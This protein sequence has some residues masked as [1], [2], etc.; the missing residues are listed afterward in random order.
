MTAESLTE[1][2]SQP[3]PCRTHGLQLI[4][5]FEGSGF[6]EPHYLARRADGHVIHLSR[7]LYLVASHIDGQRGLEEIADRVSEDFG[8]FVSADNVAYLLERKLRPLGVAAIEGV[9]TLPEWHEPLLGIKFRFAI[10]PE[11]VVNALASLL[12]PLFLPPI[13]AVVLGSVAAVYVWVFAFHGFV[14]PFLDVL[15]RP[16]TLLAIFAIGLLYTVFH[17]LGH[18]TACRYGGAR[19]GVMGVGLYIVW[20]VFYTDVTDSYRVSRRGRIRTDLGGVYFHALCILATAGLYFLTGQEWLLVLLLFTHLEMIHQFLPV[21][22]LDGYWLV[23]DLTGVPDLFGRMGPIL[24]SL[25]PGRPPEPK[26]DQ[27]KPWARRCITAW[28]LVTVPV[29]VGGLIWFIFHLPLL[30]SA[31]WEAIQAQSEAIRMARASGDWPVVAVAV[32]ELLL[33][34]LPVLATIATS[35]WISW[36]LGRAIARRWGPQRRTPAAGTPGAQPM[37]SNRDERAGHARDLRLRVGRASKRG[38]HTP[39]GELRQDGTERERGVR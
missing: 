24:R 33:L 27:L 32:L 37:P 38:V 19:P 16:L 8:R 35:A 12:G 30:A 36:R 3:V 15:H 39:G 13:V 26:V 9:D 7:L 11:R 20:P 5:D 6:V 25:L 2:P 4:G 10:M 18:A 34:V 29:L 22:R 17:E 1:A 14:D 21:V 31:S 23:S 28:V